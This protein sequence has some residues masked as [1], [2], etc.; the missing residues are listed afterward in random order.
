MNKTIKI[1]DKVHA[2]LE[3][4]RLKKETYSQAVARLINFHWEITRAVWSHSPQHPT[5]PAQGD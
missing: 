4:L 5:T 2:D 1:E 3:E